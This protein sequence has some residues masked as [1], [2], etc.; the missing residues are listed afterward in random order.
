MTLTLL[1]AFWHVAPAARRAKAAAAGLAALV[2]GMIVRRRLGL[3][4]EAWLMA[5]TGCPSSEI[6]QTTERPRLFRLSQAVTSTLM[7]STT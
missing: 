5:V 6:G 1:S 3:E 2:I 4:M 7:R